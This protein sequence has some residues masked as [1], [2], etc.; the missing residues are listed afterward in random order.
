[1]SPNM[2]MCGWGRGLGKTLIKDA[3]ATAFSPGATT[4]AVAGRRRMLR[5]GAQGGVQ[6]T[7]LFAVSPS[8]WLSLSVR[9]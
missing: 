7:I 6:I 3:H 4:V 2:F 1:M 9:M 5:N 8:Q